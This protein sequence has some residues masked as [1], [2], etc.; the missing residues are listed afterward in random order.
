M[1]KVDMFTKTPE[2]T[3]T[4]LYK[5]PVMKQKIQQAAQMFPTYTDAE[6]LQIVQP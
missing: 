2:Q 4:E 1:A 5:D 6:I 3:L